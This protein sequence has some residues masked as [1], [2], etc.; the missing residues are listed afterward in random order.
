MKLLERRGAGWEVNREIRAKLVIGAG[1]HFCPVGRQLGNRKQPYA[2]VVA[3]Q[4]VEFETDPKF[5]EQGSVRAEIPELFFCPDLLG[6]GWCFRKGNFLNIGLGRVD[7]GSVSEH[8]GAFC[9][10]LRSRGKVVCDI[11][12]RLYGH[13]Y[14]LYEHVTPRLFDDGV[15]LIGDSAGLSYP[16]SGEGIRPAVESGL[17][18]ADT[19][20]A[21]DGKYDSQHL[22]PYRQQILKRF[23]KPRAN[24]ASDMLPAGMLRFLAGRL[25]ATRWFS[26]HVILDNWFLH[27]KESALPQQYA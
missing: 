16:Q 7:R 6:Y 17:L 8:V 18:A 14:Q 4:E 2:S 25:M 24:G 13:A 5:L 12:S 23:G 15:M 26:R 1:G 11:P 9:E 27:T 3:A 19:I 10:F 22:E 20:I 21:A